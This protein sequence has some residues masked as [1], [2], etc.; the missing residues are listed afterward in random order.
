MVAELFP[1]AA[2]Q[3]PRALALDAAPRLRQ[4]VDLGSDEPPPG[5]LARGAF[6]AAA[7]AVGPDEVR[8]AAGP[9]ADPRRRRC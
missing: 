2:G 4:V 5:F 3:D 1:E 6:A 8:D 9:R 7:E